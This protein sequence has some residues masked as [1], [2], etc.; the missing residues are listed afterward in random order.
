V[1]YFPRSRSTTSAAA[2]SSVPR[3]RSFCS[4]L[5]MAASATSSPGYSG[6][7]CARARSR[8]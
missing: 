8:G 2:S 5:R 3:S 7:A 1:P 4:T 6:Q